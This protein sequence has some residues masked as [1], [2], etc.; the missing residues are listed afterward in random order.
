[1]TERAYV[2][3]ASAL[4]AVLH[5]EPGWEVAAALLPESVM[6][7]VN[8][9]EVGQK[10]RRMGESIGRLRSDMEGLGLSV[11]PFDQD[12]ADDAARLWAVTRSAGLSLGDRACL[13]LAR[14]RTVPAVTA[15]R[16][17]TAL[18]KAVGTTVKVI[19]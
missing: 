17:W 6:S 12:D 5:A 2:M 19:R 14:R 7:A 10:V 1:M 13:A 15:D 18:T 9:S 3:D 8:W 16:S 4:L 11:T